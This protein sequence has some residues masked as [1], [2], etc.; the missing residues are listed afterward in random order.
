PHVT[1]EAIGD[2]LT[3]RGATKASVSKLAFE[4]GIRLVEL[5]E[6]APSLEETFLEMTG[7][8]AEFASA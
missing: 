8:S 6:V 1:I 4:H 2:R 7:A 3:V 5:S